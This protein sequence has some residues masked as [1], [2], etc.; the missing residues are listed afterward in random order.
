PVKARTIQAKDP[1]RQEWKP[2]PT[3]ELESSPSP[4]PEPQ[5]AERLR[6]DKCLD[7]SAAAFTSPEA[8]Q[9]NYRCGSGAIGAYT[10]LGGK[11]MPLAHHQYLR[12]RDRINS[13]LDN[14]YERLSETNDYK[15]NQRDLRGIQLVVITASA[16]AT[17]V[18][19]AFAHLGRLTWWGA[20]PLA[21]G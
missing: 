6:Y 15:R 14:A 20:I 18:V 8:N 2:T 3:P 21:F 19:N 16:I 4:T 13:A 10:N 12:A 7:G 9:T 17:G 5:G 1:I 11:S